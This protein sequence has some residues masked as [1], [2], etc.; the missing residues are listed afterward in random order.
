MIRISGTQSGLSLEGTDFVSETISS[1]V[2]FERFAESDVHV[3]WNHFL[4]LGNN[5]SVVKQINFS[6]LVD[7]E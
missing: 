5:S 2:G 3:L 6:L 1:D 4:D 7:V